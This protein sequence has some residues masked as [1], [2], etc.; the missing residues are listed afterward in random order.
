MIFFLWFVLLFTEEKNNTLPISKSVLIASL[1]KCKQ[2]KVCVM[3]HIAIVRIRMQMPFCMRKHS[4]V[5]IRHLQLLSSS[6]I[7]H[8][9]SSAA[10]L[11]V[12][13][14]IFLLLGADQVRT[15]D[16]ELLKRVLVS[17]W[18]FQFTLV[19]SPWKQI[20]LGHQ[21]SALYRTMQWITFKSP[22]TRNVFNY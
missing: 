18:T 12:C 22:C 20:P 19:I 1:Q 10:L 3:A 5:C 21:Y 8:R 2:L 14:R 16:D 7:G 6:W 17:L 9:K 11:I 15:K 13:E 4:S